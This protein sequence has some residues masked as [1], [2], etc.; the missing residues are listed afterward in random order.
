[1]NQPVLLLAS[2]Q[3]GSVVRVGLIDQDIVKVGLGDPVSI[4][5][6]A[7]PGQT[8]SGVISEVALS[9]E[10]SVG[11]FEVEILIEN[12]GYTLHSGLIARVE[13]SPQLNNRQYIIPVESLYKA[14]YGAATVFILDEYENKVAAVEVKIID[15]FEDEV[16]VEG[17]LDIA[18]LIVKVGT[19]YLSDDSSVVVVD[20]L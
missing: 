2:L 13:M 16:V 9:T 3:Q 14:E 19:A 18:D 12:Q 15:L 17:S 10:S 11:T 6:D 5:L 1:S 7:Y 20:G 4:F 8:F